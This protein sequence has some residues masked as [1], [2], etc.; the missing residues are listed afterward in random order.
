MYEPIPLSFPAPQPGALVCMPFGIGGTRGGPSERLL[1]KRVLIVEDEALL[2]FEL[3]LA[4]GDEG[5]EVIGPALSLSMGMTLAENTSEIDCA[6]LDV[7]L[8]GRQVFAVAKALQARDVPLLFHT[9]RATPGELAAMFPGS[10]TV[11]KPARPEELVARLVA[12]AR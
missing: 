4:I 1:G 9:A 11:P 6:V 7:D 10:E 3:E 2:A 8:A 5:A 12:I